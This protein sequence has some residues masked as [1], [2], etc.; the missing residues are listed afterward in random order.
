MSSQLDDQ[1]VTAYAL[2]ELDEAGRL[3]VEAR[4]EREPAL[5]EEIAQIRAVAGQLAEQL[6]VEP[7]PET[8]PIKLPATAATTMKIA[9]RPRWAGRP[10]IAAAV[11]VVVGGMAISVMLPS[12]NR[13]RESSDRGRIAANLREIE[14]APLQASNDNRGAYQQSKN[15]PAGQASQPDDAK[16]VPYDDIL[17]YPTNGPDASAPRPQAAIAEPAPAVAPSLQPPA[18]LSLSTTASPA[19]SSA[20]TPLADAPAQPS[21]V[22]GSVSGLQTLS[23]NGSVN[24]GT[25]AVRGTTAV[26]RSGSNS[27]TTLNLQQQAGNRQ[28]QGGQGYV[29]SG[30]N[31]NGVAVARVGGASGGGVGAGDR[32]F[33]GATP[34]AV[35]AETSESL[36]VE[37]VKSGS[38]T[39]QL[40]T[41]EREKLR[42]E[43]LVQVERD[44][45]QFN[46]EAY[47]RVVD[48]AFLD[49][50]PNPLS[51]FSI[52]V[53]TASYA[54][55]RRFLTQGQKPPKDAVRIEEMVNYFPY[56]YDP[57]AKDAKEPFATHVE[58]ADCPWRPE[59]RLVRVA[60]K[61]K[62][63]SADKRPASNLVFLLDV[64]G[65]M[66]PENKLPM[67]KRS[68]RMLLDK[69]GGEDRVAI[70]VYAGSSGL[71]L[72]ST[73]CSEGAKDQILNAIENLS[74]GGSTNGEEGI[75]L[76]YSIAKK[77]FVE[78]GTNR[79]ILCTDGDFNVGV[80]N[81]GDLTRVIEDKAKGGVFLSVLGFGMGNLKDST[82]E[83]LADKG[84]GNYAYIDTITEAKKVLVEQM[85]G[86]LVTIAKDVKIQIEFNPAV[87]ES[88]RLIGYEN[89]LLAKEDFND[90]KKDAGEIGAGHAVTAMYEVVPVGTKPRDGDEKSTPK[91]DALKYQKLAA[92]PR[93]LAADDDGSGEMLTLK[94]RYKQ[95]DADKSALIETPVKDAGGTFAK[96]SRDFKFA[97][98]VAAFGMILRDSPHRGRATYPAVLEWAEDGVGEDKSGYRQEFIELVKKAK[99]AEGN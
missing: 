51:T 58:V 21:V 34:Y 61:G 54:N 86:T 89:R 79:V 33:S 94:L 81:Q 72:P 88:Y 36:D 69:L 31:T 44:D 87:I 28:Q 26:E 13:A 38:G 95:P 20:A 41:R 5:R 45:K 82:M 4:I 37:G 10:A 47:D 65:S 57:P 43:A 59:H 62:E 64:S 76:A 67:V 39:L 68:M 75:Q 40:A 7:A 46:T 25:L 83:K 71:V 27:V 18:Q 35:K 17:R 96:S 90:D 91:V 70:V 6:A 23:G 84:N 32:T 29:M 49:V 66:Q 12:L 16:K 99:Q 14:Q 30:G 3:E 52:D 8:K 15:A 97:S 42:R 56:D 24:G 85:S 80:T 22:T 1:K 73:A 98:S 9:R 50:M 48:N 92:D 77:N 55:V 11:S 93:G 78:G 19:E 53:D 63:I 2:G 74:A 60:I